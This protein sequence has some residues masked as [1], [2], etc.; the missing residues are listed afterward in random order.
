MKVQE[1]SKVEEWR[2]PGRAPTVRTPQ[3]GEWTDG[4]NPESNG[5]DGGTLGLMGQISPPPPKWPDFANN[6][7]LKRSFYRAG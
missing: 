3:P 2:L 5:P 4:S 1:P 7:S 6:L